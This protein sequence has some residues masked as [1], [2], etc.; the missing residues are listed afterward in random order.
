[1]RLTIT[2]S[3]LVSLSASAQL[4]SWEPIT[5]NGFTIAPQNTAPEMEVFNDTLYVAT[6][7]AGPGLA[8]LLRSGSGDVGDW[9]PVT[10]FDPPLTFDKSIHAFGVDENLGYI[11]C[12]TGNSVLGGMIYRSSNGVVW[13]SICARGFGVAGR[14]GVSPHMLT[15]QGPTDSEPYLYAGI[16]SHGGTEPGV[17]M[18]IPASSSTPSDWEPL[19]DFA[20]DP[21]K[22]IIS[23]FEV[24]EGSYGN[25][26]TVQHSLKISALVRA[27]G[28]ETLCS[29]RSKCSRIICM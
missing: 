19:V 29:P 25:R 14:T 18:R 8:R 27:S 7:P 13:D 1:M 4:H 26:L 3:L 22:T 6:S 20:F 15:F 9:T 2:L 24:E 5:E 11:W 12:G 16:G 10:T 21:A 23:Y 17:V 28:P